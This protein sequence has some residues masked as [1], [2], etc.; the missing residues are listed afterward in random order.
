MSE[1]RTRGS[2]HDPGADDSGRYRST[3]CWLAANADLAR[4][5]AELL[6]AHVLGSNRAQVLAFPERKLTEEQS[7]RLTSLADRRRG[8]EPLAYILG[9]KEFFGMD[10]RVG[11]EVLVPRPETELVV[12]LALRHAPRGALTLDLGTGSGCIAVVLKAHR[13]DL[14]VVATDR[15]LAALR[16]AKANAAAN[17]TAI[18]FVQGDWLECVSGPLGCIVANP[19]YVAEGDPALAALAGEPQ[20]ALVAG[21]DGLDAIRRIAMQTAERITPSGRLILE[22]GH[23]QGPAVRDFLALAGFRKIETHRDLA[24]IE[25]ASVAFMEG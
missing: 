5:D 9:R 19:P 21:A 18:G 15:S 7:A 22:H 6:V 1:I 3:G 17:G 23:D 24:G 13:P 4:L 25:R 10:F 8:L 20:S 12:E 14:C 2:L 11:N 16:V